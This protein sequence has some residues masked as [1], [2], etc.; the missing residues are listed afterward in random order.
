MLRINRETAVEETARRKLIHARQSLVD[1]VLIERAYL[2]KTAV[3]KS[4]SM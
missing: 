1:T 4:Y 3:Y 2:E